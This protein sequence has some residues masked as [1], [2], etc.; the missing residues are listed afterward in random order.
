MQFDHGQAHVLSRHFV[1]DF[2]E[3]LSQRKYEV[4]RIF[5][6]NLEPLLYDYA[7]VKPAERPITSPSVHDGQYTDERRI[8]LI[9]RSAGD[10]LLGATTHNHPFG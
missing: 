7:P 3:F 8:G 4:F 10:Q 5:P 2:V 6:G 9:A 1:G